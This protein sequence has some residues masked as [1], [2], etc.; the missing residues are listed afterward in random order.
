LQEKY[1][2]NECYDNTEFQAK[3]FNVQKPCYPS[4]HLYTTRLKVRIKMSA[5]QEITQT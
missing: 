5:V 2:D 4:Q 3:H 1:I